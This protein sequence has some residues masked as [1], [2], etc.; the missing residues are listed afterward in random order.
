MTGSGTPVCE[1]HAVGEAEGVRHRPVGRGD[2][3]GVGEAPE[4]RVEE[5]LVERCAVTPNEEGCS[6][7]GA[8]PVCDGHAL[9]EVGVEVGERR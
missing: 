5:L 6:R 7:A 2:A 8:E 9:E 4:Q 1:F 3:S